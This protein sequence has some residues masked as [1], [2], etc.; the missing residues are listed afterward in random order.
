[1]VEATLMKS[2]S[3]LVLAF[4]VLM[5]LIGAWLGYIGFL[6]KARN[7]ACHISA[8]EYLGDK[9]SSTSIA[10]QNVLNDFSTQNDE[11]GRQVTVMFSDTRSMNKH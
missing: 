6:T 9:S 5:L 4:I 11:V 7:R 8:M 10:F 3:L 1:M 2:T